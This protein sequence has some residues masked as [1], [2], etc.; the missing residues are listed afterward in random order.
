MLQLKD[1]NKVGYPE[2]YDLDELIVRLRTCIDDKEA[3]SLGYVSNII[4]VWERLNIGNIIP[5]LGSDQTEFTQSLVR[6]A[7]LIWMT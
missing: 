6:V 1:T 2:F 3:V 4:D 5:D 7:T